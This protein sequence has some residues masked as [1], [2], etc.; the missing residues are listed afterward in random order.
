MARLNGQVNGTVAYR[1]GDGVLLEMPRGACEI[2]IDELDVTLAWFEGDVH[3]S[4]AIPRD[5]YEQ[6]LANGDI[7]LE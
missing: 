4:A 7:A 1:E 6:Y 5:D 2:E 3:C